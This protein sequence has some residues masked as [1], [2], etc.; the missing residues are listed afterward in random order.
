MN[1]CSTRLKMMLPI[2]SHLGQAGIV[3]N[4]RNLLSQKGETRKAVPMPQQMI[5]GGGQQT[6]GFHCG[7]PAF[8]ADFRNGVRVGEQPKIP[9]RAQA[10]KKIHT[11]GQCLERVW[12]I[13]VRV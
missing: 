2:V 11:L 9:G 5:G 10:G 4:E 8:P 3:S 13:H 6:A 1:V 7:R 12:N